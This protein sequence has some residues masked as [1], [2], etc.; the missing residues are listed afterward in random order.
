[1]RVFTAR[2]ISFKG[3]RLL[4]TSFHLNIWIATDTKIFH[5]H[6][7][8]SENVKRLWNALET[9]L[10]LAQC[11]RWGKICWTLILKKYYKKIRI[12]EKFYVRWVKFDVNFSTYLRFVFHSTHT[13][14]YF[15]WELL[16]TSVGKFLLAKQ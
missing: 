5:K 9:G 8:S 16:F 2:V 10:N 7:F 13:Q 14:K 15:P 11:E 1:M 4:N 6:C 12:E 3:C